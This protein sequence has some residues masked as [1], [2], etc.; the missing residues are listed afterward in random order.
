MTAESPLMDHLIDRAVLSLRRINDKLAVVAGLALLLTAGYIL[1][2]I[3][4]RRF[5]ASFGGTDEISGYVMAGVTSWAM[6]YALTKLAHVRIDLVRVKLRPLGRALMDCLALWTLAATAL[7]VAYQ[8]WPVL[9]RS[10]RLGST[11]NTPL[12]TPL[13]IPQA[14]WWS[15]WAWFAFSASVL[16]LALLWNTSRGRV[17]E[18]EAAGGVGA[19][20]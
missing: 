14:I 2:D 9:A 19:E 16:A 12:E 10:I 15:G 17:K 3:I 7:Y 20:L 8:G 18:A 4:L 13:W 11:A 6:A 5:D 1:A